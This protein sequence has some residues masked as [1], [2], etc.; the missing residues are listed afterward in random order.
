MKTA[1]DNKII[2]YA[3]RTGRICVTLD[4][5]FHALLAMSNSTGPSVIRIR[6]EG[7]QGTQLAN[8]LL[9]ILQKVE[10]QLQRGAMVTAS[11]EM[12]RLRHLPILKED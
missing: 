3:R 6:Q 8:L 10:A 11:E 7:L 4:A 1:A 9:A 2:D 5:D 12:L